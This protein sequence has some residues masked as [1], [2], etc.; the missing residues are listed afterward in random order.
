MET[1]ALAKLGMD[2]KEIKV[3]LALVRHGLATGGKVADLTGLHRRTAYDVLASLMEKGFVTY[4]IKERKKHFDAMDP[5]R[6]MDLVKEQE[7]A[8]NSLLPELCALRAR[9][10]EKSGVQIYEGVKSVKKIYD[11]L[12]ES[13]SYVALGAGEPLREMLGPFFAFFQRRKRQMRAKTRVII[14]AA[15][16]KS[17]VVTRTYGDVRLLEGYEAPTTT[18]VYGNKV[19]IVICDPP[20]GIVIENGKVAASFMGYFNLLWSMAKPA[21]R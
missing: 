4:V 6:L 19:A 7:D 21:S 8:V 12:L 11:E 3:Y 5:K 9:R 15:Y 1:A 10:K 18:Y 2:E 14:S 16:R 20:L 17:E 13:G